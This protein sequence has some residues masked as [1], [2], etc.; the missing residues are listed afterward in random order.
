MAG[1][2]PGLRAT[3]SQ[4]HHAP[5]AP[6]ATATAAPAPKPS[7]AFAGKPAPKEGGPSSRQQ[8]PM[9]H[10]G[11]IGKA[12]K[13]GNHAMAMHHIGHLLR[14]VKA[15]SIAKTPLN[16]TPIQ[17]DDTEQGGF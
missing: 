8:S 9:F 7:G 1:N 5:M 2:I 17:S 11:M 12:L 3:L 4:W 13:A 14:T 10:H 6:P 16:N 15:A